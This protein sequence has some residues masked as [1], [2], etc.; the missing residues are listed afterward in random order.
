MYDEK[1]TRG[2]GLMPSGD[3]PDGSMVVDHFN[4]NCTAMHDISTMIT[5]D[6][7]CAKDIIHSFSSMLAAGVDIPEDVKV[8]MYELM[9]NQAKTLCVSEH[10]RFKEQSSFLQL[11]AE[12]KLKMDKSQVDTV[13]KITK[14][15]MDE[16]TRFHTGVRS[17]ANTQDVSTRA[18]TNMI[19]ELLDEQFKK[20]PQ[21][22]PSAGTRKRKRSP[23]R[24]L[25]EHD[26]NAILGAI[27]AEKFLPSHGGTLPFDDAALMKER[28]SAWTKK[29]PALSD[30]FGSLSSKYRKDEHNLSSYEELMKILPDSLSQANKAAL[31]QMMQIMRIYFQ[32][33]SYIMTSEIQTGLRDLFSSPLAVVSYKHN[34]TFI[35]LTPIRSHYYVIRSMF[36]RCGIDGDE[37][38]SIGFGDSPVFNVADLPLVVF[39]KEA[40]KSYEVMALRTPTALECFKGSNPVVGYLNMADPVSQSP[41]PT[42]ALYILPTS[43]FIHLWHGVSKMYRND[44]HVTKMFT[45]LKESPLLSDQVFVENYNRLPRRI[46]TVKRL[47][48]IDDVEDETVE[49]IKSL[50]ICLPHRAV[51]QTPPI[52][53]YRSSGA[54]GIYKYNGRVLQPAK[55]ANAT[56]FMDNDVRDSLSFSRTQ[57]KPKHCLTCPRLETPDFLE[58]AQ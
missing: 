37:L 15:K 35:H 14:T 1:A 10:D 29:L 43:I 33:V 42:N 30:C 52:I 50:E 40:D 27:D 32:V 17:V 2:S 8:S 26:Y 24:E 9:K 39:D 4:T 58:F 49:A 54:G 21:T 22:L 13:Q 45:L 19:R 23:E 55:P 38:E 53:L 51:C 47:C 28:N 46:T 41:N 25:Y 16:M 20:L 57:S 56:K 44:S 12:Q 5:N 7:V 48:K 11:A 3:N 18:Q 6:S 34:Q 31:K 36:K